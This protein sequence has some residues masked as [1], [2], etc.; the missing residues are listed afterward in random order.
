MFKHKIKHKIKHQVPI[1]HAY[2]HVYLG[3]ACRA[4]VRRFLVHKFPTIADAEEACQIT[5][6]GP[7][8]LSRPS[9]SARISMLR[10]S[11]TS[12]KNLAHLLGYVIDMMNW[13]DIAGSTDDAEGIFAF[14]HRLLGPIF[15]EKDFHDAF[16]KS[17]L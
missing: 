16:P 8:K 7:S 11:P 17:Y 1:I 12:G 5:Y 3:S 15:D 9:T 4:K 14:L 6:I 13:H 10:L 2:N